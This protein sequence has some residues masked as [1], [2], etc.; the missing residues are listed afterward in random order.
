MRLHKVNKYG[1]SS[2]SEIVHCSHIYRM[3]YV[4]MYMGRMIVS[5]MVYIASVA[6]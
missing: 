4:M 1:M 6:V 3:I 5:G 2:R